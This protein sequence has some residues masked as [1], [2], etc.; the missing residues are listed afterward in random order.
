MFKTTF[1][2]LLIPKSYLSSNRGVYKIY[3]HVFLR[4]QD[5]RE[6]TERIFYQNKQSTLGQ[7][8]IIQ[9]HNDYGY[10]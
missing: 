1:V 5:E 10:R 8:Q 2:M 6:Y 9:S 7:R 4:I 3:R